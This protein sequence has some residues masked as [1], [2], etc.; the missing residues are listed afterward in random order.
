VKHIP[1]EW[2]AA[3]YDGEL[4]GA[5]RQQVE[6]HLEHCEICQI[7]LEA[8]GGLSQWLESAPAP[9]LHTSRERFASQVML[10]VPRFIE[11]T[12]AQRVGQWLW[13]VA[14]LTILAAWAFLQVLTFVVPV[15]A[16]LLGQGSGLPTMAFSMP[17]LALDNLLPL[18]S[19]FSGVIN[20]FLVFAVD[21]VLSLLLAGLLWSWLASWWVIK[22][23]TL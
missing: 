10:R 17:D 7:E 5:H 15:G 23:N 13:R 16:W 18:L 6:A 8:L 4:R 21:F 14:P 9:R 22:R 11:P 1:V 19:H 2:I 3:Y 12:G 20:L